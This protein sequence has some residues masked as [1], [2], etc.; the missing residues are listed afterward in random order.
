MGTPKRRA[1]SEICPSWYGQ[2]DLLLL[3]FAL[4]ADVGPMGPLVGLDVLEA[5]LGVAN[6]VELLP[7]RAAMSRAPA[8]HCCLLP[9]TNRSYADR[10]HI[11]QFC[12]P[13]PTRQ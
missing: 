5:T 7:G 8:G 2:L 12:G 4:A 1:R 6:G 13:G 3:A 11:R 10:Y 9:E